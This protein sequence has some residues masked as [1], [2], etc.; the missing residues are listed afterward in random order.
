MR[1]STFHSAVLFDILPD[2]IESGC[3]RYSHKELHPLELRK[4]RQ[5][6]PYPLHLY[7]QNTMLP[8]GL[9]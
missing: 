5:P 4:H 2:W 9:M 7:R 3:D 6:H 1:V 8:E